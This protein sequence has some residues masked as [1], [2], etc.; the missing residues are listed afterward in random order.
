MY[1]QAQ[2]LARSRSYR[3]AYFNRSFVS[4]VSRFSVKYG[5]DPNYIASLVKPDTNVYLYENNNFNRYVDRLRAQFD[6]NEDYERVRN[7]LARDFRRGYY[8]LNGNRRRLRTLSQL[9]ER[10]KKIRITRT[11]TIPVA[12]VEGVINTASKINLNQR[13]TFGDLSNN[14]RN[15]LSEKVGLEKN[16]SPG[17]NYVLSRSDKEYLIKA[18]SPSHGLPTSDDNVKRWLTLT[19]NRQQPVPFA[20]VNTPQGKNEYAKIVND[21]NAY[22]IEKFSDVKPIVSRIGGGTTIFT[23]ADVKNYFMKRDGVKYNNDDYVM[24]TQNEIRDV[25]AMAY[26][27][28]KSFLKN[29]AGFADVIRGYRND[30]K[31]R[32]IVHETTGAAAVSFVKTVGEGIV[33]GPLSLQSFAHQLTT[34]PKRTINNLPVALEREFNRLYSGITSGD[35]IKIASAIGEIAGGIMLAYGTFGKLVR[36]GLIKSVKRRVILLKRGLVQRLK[37]TRNAFG[38]F[39]YRR[40]RIRNLDELTLW[41]RIKGRKLTADDVIIL[42][43]KGKTGTRKGQVQGEVSKTKKET[44]RGEITGRG[45][46]GKRVEV[47]KKVQREIKER[48]DIT[49][50]DPKTGSFVN[51]PNDLIRKR[52]VIIKKQYVSQDNFNELMASL[53]SNQRVKIIKSSSLIKDFMNLYKGV[54]KP[55]QL[56]MMTKV[57]NRYLVRVLEFNKNNVLTK[58]S[59]LKLSSS[60]SGNLKIK[61]KHYVRDGNNRITFDAKGRISVSKFKEQPKTKELIHVKREGSVIKK[62]PVKSVKKA[63]HPK[64]RVRKIVQ[65]FREGGRSKKLVTL[66]V[67][68]KK[69]TITTASWKNFT[70]LQKIQ[71]FKGLQRLRLI[72]IKDYRGNKFD[73]YFDV[74]GVGSNFK[75]PLNDYLK[76]LSRPAAVQVRTRINK[77]KKTGK[78]KATPSV[79]ASFDRVSPSLVQK[80]KSVGKP[81]NF[82]RL[83]KSVQDNVITKIL[84]NVKDKTKGTK[85]TFS[86]T[87]GEISVLLTKG[88]TDATARTFAANFF[89]L[90]QSQ[91][92]RENVQNATFPRTIIRYSSSQRES[93][94]YVTIP[95][96][97]IVSRL[98][99]PRITTRRTV[100]VTTRRT[101]RRR[102]RR[103]KIPTPEKKRVIRRKIIK[104]TR[105]YFI[106]VGNKRLLRT[107]YSLTDA[108]DYL[109]YRLRKTS[110]NAG[111]VRYG[112]TFT[113]IGKL[114][115]R[116]KGH[117]AQNKRFF[118]A[119]RVGNNVHLSIKRK[120]GVRKR[121]T[122]KSVRRRVVRRR[123]VRRSVR[124]RK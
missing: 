44:K 12:R 119:K 66:N 28:L 96:T 40:S 93:Q 71:V 89:R 107:P 84:N 4:A 100:P 112:G 42:N 102:R 87:A 64:Q 114:N 26:V 21:G 117:H 39:L 122:K 104:R 1:N 72:R 75:L 32:G 123:I 62:T 57:G 27:F 82:Q 80:K 50:V 101:T 23:S 58:I 65:K 56:I 8:V 33:L 19:Y 73:V 36:K 105:G 98:T 24:Y 10:L 20:Y 85:I 99:T 14:Y 55:R 63:T 31:N 67:G 91:A 15:I 70:R 90:V 52:A 108:V 74:K 121:A 120:M 49:F 92:A 25:Y 76:T 51:F 116:V 3:Q 7:E 68:G 22:Q 11:E 46:I 35:R 9:N 113:K 124:R 81:V 2:R 60:L 54:R 97:I 109:S 118:T 94:K 110:A 111:M 115:E 29:E 78:G 86:R 95:R 17:R 6:N 106:Y 77:F 48:Q 43:R 88:I 38:R 41:S 37:Q 61:G 59:N 13:V 103:I 53:T 47:R 79:L 45:K 5:V 69:V 34:D 16:L 83:P 30:M 18:Q